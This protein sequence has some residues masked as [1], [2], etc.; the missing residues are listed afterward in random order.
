MNDFV[1]AAQLAALARDLPKVDLHR[2]LEGS[3]RVETLIDVALTYDLTLPATDVEGLRPHVQIMPGDPR[4]W[5]HFLSKFSVL[6]MF[7]IS[8]EVIMRVTRE[9]VEDAAR[10]NI[11]YLELRFTPRALCNVISCAFT[12]AVGWVCYA[13]QEASRD[14]GIEVRLILSMNRHEG[15]IL[16][17]KVL[18][19]AVDHQAHGVVAIDLAGREPE[20]PAE[21]FAGLFREAAASGL[22]IT[23]HAGEWGSAKNVR[24]AVERLGATR[25]GH[26]VR[27]IGDST[28]V[29]MLAERGVTLELCPTSNIQSGVVADMPTHPIADLYYSRIATTINTDDPL[30]SNITLS[31]EIAAILTHTPLTL[32]DVKKQILNGVRASFLPPHERDQLIAQFE[33]VLLT[34]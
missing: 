21:P 31:A 4:S 13:A 2:H 14:F 33:N 30:I 16:G 3:I 26:G 17:E 27:S 15:L 19:A 34:L 23:V 10:D 22:G 29:Q 6:R 8:P 12:D 1:D 7:F 5:E 32:A 24:E 11:R 18:R 28:V 20:Y 25:I 9:A